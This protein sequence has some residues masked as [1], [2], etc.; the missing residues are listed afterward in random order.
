VHVTVGP[1]AKGPGSC[2]FYVVTTMPANYVP[3]VGMKAKE[4]RMKWLP[5]GPV[6]N[7]Q[8]NT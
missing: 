2:L 4:L 1:P 5:A 8:P 3:Q 6:A 7:L